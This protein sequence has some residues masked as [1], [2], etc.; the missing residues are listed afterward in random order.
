VFFLASRFRAI[1][2]VCPV[3][4]AA[5][6]RR[7]GAFGLEARS[8]SVALVELPLALTVQRRRTSLVVEGERAFIR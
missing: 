4:P 6:G 8:G 7:R 5:F 2:T 3:A 1:P